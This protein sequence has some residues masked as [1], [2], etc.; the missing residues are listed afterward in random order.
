MVFSSSSGLTL[1]GVMLVKSFQ[2]SGE[3]DSIRLDPETVVL[4]F[5]KC[6]YLS[7]GSE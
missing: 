2:V 4:S 5:S 7:S 6:F 3:E 1:K